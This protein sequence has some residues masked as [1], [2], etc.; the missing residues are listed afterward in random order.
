MNEIADITFGCAGLKE[1]EFPFHYQRFPMEVADEDADTLISTE[2]AY[3]L[4]KG[5]M[6]KNK[7]D[8]G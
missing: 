2:Y 3:F 5:L 1:K 6:N 8:R 7:I 4:S